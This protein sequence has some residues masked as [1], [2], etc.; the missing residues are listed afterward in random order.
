MTE[1]SL[2]RSEW[3]H[4]VRLSIYCLQPT[5]NYMNTAYSAAGTQDRRDPAS[6]TVPSPRCA[7]LAHQAQ[8]LQRADSKA[9]I[10][11]LQRRHDHLPS[12]MAA[13][14]ESARTRSAGPGR[15]HSSLET[16]LMLYTTRHSTQVG[17]AV[18]PLSHSSPLRP[19]M[20][21]SPQ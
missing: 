1:P 17:L 14:M 5:E 3:C 20:K 10:E 11:Q 16:Q 8:Q 18:S 13:E 12:I 19:S 7:K 9:R 2:P 21:P 4:A 15:S 6:E